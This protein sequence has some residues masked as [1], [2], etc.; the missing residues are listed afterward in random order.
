[1]AQAVCRQRVIAEDLAELWFN[2]LG[3]G[4]GRSGNGTGLYQSTS[5]F[6][7]HPRSTNASFSPFNLTPML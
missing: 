2:P 7:C 4:G 3:T 6:P 5:D 1:M